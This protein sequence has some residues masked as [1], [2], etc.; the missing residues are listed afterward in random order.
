[1]MARQCHVMAQV[2]AEMRQASE[3]ASGRKGKGS[4]EMPSSCS[5]LASARLASPWMLRAG[6]SPSCM[7]RAAVA[8]SLP[9]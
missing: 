6:A 7:A 3:P 4:T 2:Q 9:T 5:A 8:K 1:V